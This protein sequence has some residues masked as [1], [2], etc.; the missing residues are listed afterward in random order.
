MITDRVI[1]R[2]PLAV[3]AIERN[4]R[5][6]KAKGGIVGLDIDAVTQETHNLALHLASHEAREFLDVA[7]Y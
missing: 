4:L 1:D 3:A 6:L 2:A 5:G 7:Q